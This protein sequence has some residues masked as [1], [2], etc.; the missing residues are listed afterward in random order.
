MRLTSLPQGHMNSMQEFCR[1]T[2]HMIRE[3]YPK[4]RVFVDD[5]SGKGP[6]TIY[7]GEMIEGNT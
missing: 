7:N 2:E 1:R 3:L 6:S 4:I 5:V